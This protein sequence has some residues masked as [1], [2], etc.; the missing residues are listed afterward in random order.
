VNAANIGPAESG[1]ARQSRPP[2]LIRATRWPAPKQSYTVQPGIPAGRSRSWMPQPKSAPRWRHGDPAAL[3][4]AKSAERAN[5]SAAQHSPKQFAQSARR[6]S[7]AITQPLSVQ[8]TGSPNAANS[9]G[10]RNA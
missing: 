9:P 5:G 4:N 1:S 7:A 6:S 3:S 10:S 8:T 2:K